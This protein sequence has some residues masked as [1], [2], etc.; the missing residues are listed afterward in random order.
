LQTIVNAWNPGDP[1]P[2][3]PRAAADLQQR[4]WTAV[5]SI[6]AA[7]IAGR[8]NF[9]VLFS[10]LRTPQQYQMY[11]REYR[12]AGGSR[13][14][15]ANRPVFVG[16]DD[17]DA[18]GCAEHALRLL[19]RRF[20]R[21]GKIN[22]SVAEPASPPDLCGHPLNFIVGGPQTVA[23]KL[24]ELHQTVPFDVANVEVRWAGLSHEQVCDSLRRLMR[25]VIPAI[26]AAGYGSTA[27]VGW[28]WA[29]R[30]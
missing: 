22:A 6:A 16:A 21:E 2:L 25:D 28:R 17:D 1:T 10:H 27:A 20:A 24:M 3:L 7:R 18:F 4:C 14:I 11:V 26:K 29:S 9:N 8:F 12:D 23:R 13:L 5:N 15:A 19:W 30:D